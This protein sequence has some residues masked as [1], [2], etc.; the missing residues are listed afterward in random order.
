MRIFKPAVHTPGTY[1]FCKLTQRGHEIVLW[2]TGNR[3]CQ[4]RDHWRPRPQN[5]QWTTSFDEIYRCDVAVMHLGSW[6]KIQP[7]FLKIKRSGIP[8]IV[9][10]HG[11]RATPALK[12]VVAGEIALVNSPAAKRT[13]GAD[14]DSTVCLSSVDVSEWPQATGRKRV[15][16]DFGKAQNEM[17]GMVRREIPIDILRKPSWKKYKAALA[18]ALIYVMLASIQNFPRSR[19]EAMACG[20]AVVSIAPAGEDGVYK[21][22]EHMMLVQSPEQA[23]KAIR[24]LMRHPR[25]AHRMGQRARAYISNVQTL[26]AWLDGVEGLLKRAVENGSR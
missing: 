16:V 3:L 5:V 7:E 20:L 8:R 24:F 12:K 22:G 6:T 9:H 13:W 18:D 1:E 26:D 19:V 14:V 17:I 21:D 2:E 23:I 10:L 4:W 11:N 15:V 25:D